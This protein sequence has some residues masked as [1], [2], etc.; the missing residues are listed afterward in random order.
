MHDTNP[1]IVKKKIY[2]LTNNKLSKEDYTIQW[3]FTMKNCKSVFKSFAMSESAHLFSCNNWRTD[4]PLKN[5]I[6]WN[7]TLCGSRQN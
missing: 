3:I 1:H 6:F 4:D 5:A 7:V 2:Q